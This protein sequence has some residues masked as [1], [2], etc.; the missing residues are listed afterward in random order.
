YF[1][2][3]AACCVRGRDDPYVMLRDVGL[4]KS[5]GNYDFRC[6]IGLTLRSAVGCWRFYPT[7]CVVNS[8]AINVKGVFNANAFAVLF[9]LSAILAIRVIL[10]AVIRALGLPPKTGG[11]T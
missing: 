9:C 2:R 3:A 6:R 4:F 7:I 8:T 11:A 1:D 10:N 5:S